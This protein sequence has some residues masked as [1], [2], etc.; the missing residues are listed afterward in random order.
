M[1]QRELLTLRHQLQL[2]A[3]LNPD[4]F[5]SAASTGRKLTSY[6][7]TQ[8]SVQTND[9]TP[10][11]PFSADRMAQP[12][13]VG[14]RHGQLQQQDYRIEERSNHHTNEMPIRRRFPSQEPAIL[15]PANKELVY[16]R[17]QAH[18]L[19]NHSDMPLQ[20]PSLSDRMEEKMRPSMYGGVM[21]GAGAQA[22][23]AAFSHMDHT[24]K[25][26]TTRFNQQQP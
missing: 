12:R 11:R 2:K 16:Q 17:V 20:M 26:P 15:D 25:P 4:N 9:P 23:T 7:A 13:T 24:N 21:S 6:N 18:H 22:T 8:S 14:L 19:P 10:N 3:D 1:T 5:K